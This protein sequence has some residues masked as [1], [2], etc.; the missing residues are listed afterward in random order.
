M[1]TLLEEY[2]SQIE[3][4]E[5]LKSKRRNLIMLSTVLI[6]LNL[7]G[8]VIKEANT[9]LFKIEFT[10]QHGINELFFFSLCYLLLRYYTYAQQYHQKLTQLWCDDMFSDRKVFF[11]H[12]E[13]EVIDGLT[14]HCL[15]M[16]GG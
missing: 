3:F 6:A 12:P 14:S 13:D 10:D 8:A 9:F 7:S 4:D 15:Q 5:G 1:S 16:W 11:F 2:R